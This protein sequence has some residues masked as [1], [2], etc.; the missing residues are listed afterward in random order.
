[1]RLEEIQT[2]RDVRERVKWRE[3]RR[4]K[5]QHASS[6]CG[7]CTR[8][9]RAVKSREREGKLNQNEATTCVD[10]R[11]LLSNFIKNT[12]SNFIKNIWNHVMIHEWEMN[13]K[14]NDGLST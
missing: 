7:F 2:S 4:S 5:V 6:S 11:P 14:R 13:A 8:S 12:L 1:M 3:W 10:L 9:D